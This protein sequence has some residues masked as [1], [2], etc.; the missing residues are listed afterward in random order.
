MDQLYLNVLGTIAFAISAIIFLKIMYDII[1]ERWID[2]E[3]FVNA[4]LSF[5]I[6]LAG[7][8]LIWGL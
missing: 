6:L 5:M 4:S 8:V 2:L 1:F 7:I 3:T